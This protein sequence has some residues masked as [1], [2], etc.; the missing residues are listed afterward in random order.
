MN[1]CAGIP[2]KGWIDALLGFVYPNVCQICEMER[3]MPAAGYVCERCWT[4]PGGIQ[5]VRPPFCER[6]G[7]PFEGEITNKFECGNCREMDLSFRFARAA[8]AASGLVL[9]VIHRYK[10]RR[11]VWFEPFLADLLIRE[12]CQALHQSEWDL[13]VPVPLHSLRK[14]ER[15]FN[16]AERLARRLSFAT[17]IPCAHGLLKRRAPTRTQTLLSRSERAANVAK[18]FVYLPNRHLRG[19]RIVL[20]DDVLTTGA[21]ASAC[22]KALRRNGAGDVCVWTVARGV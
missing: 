17:G 16:Q 7:L 21:T 3:A 11:A 20:V 1:C 14:R 2:I 5:F 15:E 22:A 9:E 6:C 13:I 18:A 12:A 8:V 10:Y 4:R 19:A